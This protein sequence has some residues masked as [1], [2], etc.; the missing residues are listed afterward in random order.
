MTMKIISGILILVTV[1][2][3]FKHGWAM[4]KAKP[5]EV[6]LFAKWKL[7]KTTLNVLAWLTLAGG[8]LIIFPETFVGGNILNAALILVIMGFHLKYKENKA[9]AMEI[10]FLLIP[11]V[12]IYL[13][14]PTF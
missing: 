8:L 1:F 12:M 3:N 7:S 2:L 4:L 11:L 5:E 6:A 14:Y 10:P 13:G 9:A